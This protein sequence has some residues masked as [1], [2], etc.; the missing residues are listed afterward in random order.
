MKLL[1]DVTCNFNRNSIQ[2]QV[3]LN[4]IH[5]IQLKISKMKIVE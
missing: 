4:W 1:N 2:I 5:D 3:Q